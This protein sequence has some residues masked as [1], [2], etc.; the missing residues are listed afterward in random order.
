[1]ARRL[2]KRRSQRIR[3][4]LSPFLVALVSAESYPFRVLRVLGW[5]QNR[6][7]AKEAYM[8]SHAASEAKQTVAMYDTRDNRR[9]MCAFAFRAKRPRW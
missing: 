3:K 2:P 5:H 1:M 7:E 8:T 9:N 4:D 6:G